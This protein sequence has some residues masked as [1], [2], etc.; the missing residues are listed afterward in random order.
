VLSIL[1]KSGLTLNRKKCKFGAKEIQFWGLLVSA[2]GIRSDP[3]KVEALNHLITPNNKEEL[4]SF[5]LHEF[6]V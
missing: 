1:A 4:V 5:L 3:E 6:Q 2:E